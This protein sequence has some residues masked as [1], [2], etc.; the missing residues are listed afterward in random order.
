MANPT[1]TKFG[2]TSEWAVIRRNCG[3]RIKT[4]ADGYR[5]LWPPS[6][7]RISRGFANH[8]GVEPVFNIFPV[9]AAA[10]VYVSAWNGDSFCTCGRLVRLLV[11]CFR[12]QFMRRASCNSLRLAPKCFRVSVP[13]IRLH[14]HELERMLGGVVPL[15]PL[16]I[17]ASLR[18]STAQVRNR[19]FLE[20]P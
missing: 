16:A 3:S 11:M 20:P 10:R 6:M 18:T 9:H 14:A 8:T 15:S 4:R 13:K 5:R 12:A 1:V 7:S 2:A 17:Q 19:Y